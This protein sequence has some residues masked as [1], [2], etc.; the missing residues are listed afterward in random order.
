[1]PFLSGAAAAA[2]APHPLVFLP[3]LPL[4]QKWLRRRLPRVYAL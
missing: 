4:L 1:M 3:Q 2:V